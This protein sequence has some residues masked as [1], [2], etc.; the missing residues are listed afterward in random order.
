M[1]TGNNW[2]YHGDHFVMYKTIDS[3]CCVP[4]TNTVMQ[5]NYTSNKHLLAMILDLWLSEAGEREELDE[6]S[7]KLQLPVIR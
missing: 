6:G 1:V 7:Q 4:K 5:I 2:N 3:P